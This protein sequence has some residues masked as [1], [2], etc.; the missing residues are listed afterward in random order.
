MNPEINDKSIE[1]VNP[2]N[3][4]QYAEHFDYEGEEEE[5]SFVQTM[6]VSEGVNCEVYNFIENEGR[7]LG[8][9]K[10]EPGKKTPLQKVLKGEKTIEG[11]LSGK[12]KL[13]I[14]KPD[15]T[16]E[17]FVADGLNKEPIIITV[18]IGETMQWEADA[19]SDL[20]AFE[21]CI[22]PYEDGRFENIE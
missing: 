14:T 17:L 1:G 5:V 19:E 22:P 9:I 12:G 11:Y 10:I 2:K 20:T 6:H 21:L 4:P 8:I 13:T 15:G 16:Q 7:D 3:S 18:N